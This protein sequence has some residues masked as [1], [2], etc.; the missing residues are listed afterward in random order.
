[1]SPGLRLGAFAAIVALAFGAA[2][3][4]GAALDPDVR[5][6]K[7]EH[8]E[9]TMPSEETQHAQGSEQQAHEQAA[10]HDAH[11][12]SEPAG[13]AAAQSGYRMVPE[14]T[15]AE[16][17]EDAAYRFRIL[18][19]EGEPL[20]DYDTTHE[21][22]MHLIL[23][24][25]DF[26]EFQHLHPRQRGDGAW[27]TTADLRAPGTYR[28][29]ADFSTGGEGLT[30][31]SDLFV[32]GDFHPAPLPEPTRKA[33]AGGGYEVRLANRAEPRTG[34]P[35]PLRFRV[36]DDG[37]PVDELEPYLGADGHLV[38]LREHD[39]A[40]LHTHPEGEA[41]GSGPIEFNVSYPT[42]GRYR[43]YLQ[44]KHDGEVHTAEFTQA[45]GEVGPVLANGAAIGR[46][47]GEPGHGH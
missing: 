31:A 35:T 1:V 15:I 22:R 9:G 19:D 38:A 12:A 23:V 21:R 29:F 28:V 14:T 5:E 18:D 27:E 33:P 4:A 24:R 47:H 45:V 3:L 26:T 46:G 40:F 13:L 37:E 32:E 25:R 36:L 11:G 2:T 10:G 8:E 30:L 17:S 43:L 39:Q 20:R 34:E 41:G 44:F 16:P 7:D 42:P 6:Q